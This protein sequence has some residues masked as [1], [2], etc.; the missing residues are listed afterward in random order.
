[1]ASASLI[2]VPSN[3]RTTA[4]MATQTMLADL[5][6]EHF[7]AHNTTHLL[8]TVLQHLMHLGFGPHADP[9][10]KTG[11]VSRDTAGSQIK[12]QP[13]SVQQHAQGVP[14]HMGHMTQASQSDSGSS[15]EQRPLLAGR[16]W[17]EPTSGARGNHFGDRETHLGIRNMHPGVTETHSGVRE[18][19]RGV[20]ETHP[21]VRYSAVEVASTADEEEALMSATAHGTVSQLSSAAM[22]GSCQANAYAQSQSDSDTAGQTLEHATVTDMTHQQSPMQ[23]QQQQQQWQLQQQQ[24]QSVLAQREMFRDASG[25]MSNQIGRSNLSS[26]DEASG[27]DTTRHRPT[28]P[29][30]ALQ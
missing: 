3:R 27:P 8:P 26:I 22:S 23:R 24:P 11:M 21:G 5:D 4:E 28:A 9:T 13:L 18:P 15:P 1:M 6:S 16:P 7:H 14:E 19:Q 20:R 25:G 17:Q 10:H 12:S 30:K 29:S 2:A